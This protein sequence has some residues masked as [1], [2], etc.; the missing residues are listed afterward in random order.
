MNEAENV[1]IKLAHLPIL[2]RKRLA[3]EKVERWLK[4]QYLKIQKKGK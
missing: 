4:I 2:S 1:G 3:D